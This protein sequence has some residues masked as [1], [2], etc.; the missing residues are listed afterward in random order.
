MELTHLVTHLSPV[1]TD[2]D[3]KE[4]AAPKG[5]PI[6]WLFCMELTHL[7]T[8]LAIAIT[9]LH[10]FRWK[11]KGCTQRQAHLT[12]HLACMTHLVTH[13]AIV[14]SEQF[15]NNGFQPVDDKE[16]SEIIVMNNLFAKIKASKTAVGVQQVSNKN[17]CCACMNW[18][19]GPGCG[20]VVCSSC[21]N[22]IQKETMPKEQG[23]AGSHKGRE[24]RQKVTRH[25]EQANYD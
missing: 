13:L 1:C 17:K 25:A 21:W 23:V 4:K 7:V 12:P 24:K 22:K 3:G 2:S 11:R 9:R 6:W 5:E 8:H 20:A 19:T 14:V 15:P 18:G 10:R 16:T